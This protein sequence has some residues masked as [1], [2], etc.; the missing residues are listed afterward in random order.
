MPLYVGANLTPRHIDVF[1]DYSQ[2]AES[3]QLDLVLINSSALTISNATKRH[4]F[5]CVIWRL[6]QFEAM[7]HELRSF[8]ERIG[9]VDATRDLVNNIEDTLSAAIKPVQFFIIDVGVSR[10]LLSIPCHH[11][12]RASKIRGV[13]EDTRL[14]YGL[15]S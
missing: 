9:T 12:W 4:A 14:Y 15:L 10:F 13:R 3:K 8:R 1:G 2:G 6:E 11:P 7:P 5:C